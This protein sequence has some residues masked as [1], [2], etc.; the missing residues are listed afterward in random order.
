MKKIYE[1]LFLFFE[2]ILV[3]TWISEHGV[4]SFSCSE[5]N[6]NMTST[7][8]PVEVKELSIVL[9]ANCCLEQ[10]LMSTEISLTLPV[11]TKKPNSEHVDSVR[12]VLDEFRRENLDNYYFNASKDGTFSLTILYFDSAG[13]DSA[14]FTCH[15]RLFI[16]CL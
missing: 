3:L 6:L 13:I 8:P 11:T 12:A 14:C 7:T 4:K 1:L 15:M 5:E 2:V 10:T 16:V 9:F